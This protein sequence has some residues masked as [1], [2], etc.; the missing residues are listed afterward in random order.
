[1]VACQQVSIIPKSFAS[2]LEK[3]KV[4]ETLVIFFLK[5]QNNG[6]KKC[7]ITSSSLIIFFTKSYERA[8]VS[9]QV[10]F[11]NF[12]SATLKSTWKLF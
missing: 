2:L 4:A 8:E 1:M 10:L 12:P 5:Y 6:Y 7:L 9:I 3:D 11:K